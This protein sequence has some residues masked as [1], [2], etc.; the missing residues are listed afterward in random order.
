M[1]EAHSFLADERGVLAVSG[2]DRKAFLQGLITNDVEKIAPQRAIHAALLTPQGRYLHDFFMVEDGETLLID[3][4]RARLPELQKKLSMFKLRSKVTL[5]DQSDRW[6]VA[7]IWGDGA[8]EALKLPGEPGSASAFEGGIAYVDPRLGAMGC[9]AVLPSDKAAASL[10]LAGLTPAD[11][12][13]WDIHRLALGVP[14]GSRDLPVEKA[15]LLESGFDELNGIDWKK[16]CYMGQELT[17]RTKYRGL[18][19]KR[20]LPVTIEGA[21][22]APGTLVMLGEKE[23]GEMRSGRDGHALAML[24]LEM[25]E[26]AKQSGPLTA[27]AAT[28]T[29]HLPAW[30]KLP[31]VSDS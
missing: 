21:M 18:V 30:V 5:E 14:D 4:E 2:P 6:A 28:V 27:G 7:V 31:E 19:R 24:R 29:A 23:A 22:P 15:F 1:A 26:A 3:C 11:Q 13:Q 20:L 8:R 25:V 10:S 17:A 12:A 9:R 16:G